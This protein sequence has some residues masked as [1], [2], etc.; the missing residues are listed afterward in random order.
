MQNMK[1]IYIYIYLLWKRILGKE[2]SK[3]TAQESAQPLDI[4]PTATQ[5]ATETEELKFQLGEVNRIRS[6][7]KRLTK[8]AVKKL[9]DY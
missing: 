1:Y 4:C 6:T 9:A 5:P 3:Q 8:T 7:E 2:I